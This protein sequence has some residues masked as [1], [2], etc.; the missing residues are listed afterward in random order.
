[1]SWSDVQAHTFSRYAED[2]EV[3]CRSMEAEIQPE[4]IFSVDLV[5]H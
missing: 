5:G 2:D 4:L 3:K 1:M